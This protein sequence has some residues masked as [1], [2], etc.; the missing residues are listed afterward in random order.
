MFNKFYIRNKRSS[1]IRSEI[2]ITPL[3]DVMTVLMAV[4]MITAPMMTSGVNVDLPNAGKSTLSDNSTSLDIVVLK[5][6]NILLSAKKI[7][8]FKSLISK[9]NSIR[10]ENPNI[11]IV[12]SGDKNVKYGKIIELMGQL[13]DAG[14]QKVGL[15]TVMNIKNQ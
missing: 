11:S 5:N 12:I 7:K 9:I 10:K 8:S 15:K 4:F 1:H 14:Y 3:I 6:G 13:K 2:N